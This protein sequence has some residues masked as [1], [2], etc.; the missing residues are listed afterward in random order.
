MRVIID[1][2]GSVQPEKSTKTENKAENIGESL[3]T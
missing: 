2:G 1:L 3:M